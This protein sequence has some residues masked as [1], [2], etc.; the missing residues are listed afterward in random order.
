MKVASFILRSTAIGMAAA[1]V[2]CMM[3]AHLCASL[4]DAD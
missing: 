4:G 2:A 3:I 1:S